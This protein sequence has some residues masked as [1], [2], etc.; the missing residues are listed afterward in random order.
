MT[1]N[2][3][4]QLKAAFIA[5]IV[6]PVALHVLNTKTMPWW[7]DTVSMGIVFG[8]VAALV[9]AKWEADREMKRRMF[10]ALKDLLLRM[11]SR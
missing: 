3:A 6:I 4:L 11:N 1:S 2:I 8:A 7:P 5:G 9:A 10:H